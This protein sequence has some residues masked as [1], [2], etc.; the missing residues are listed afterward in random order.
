MQLQAFFPDAMFLAPDVADTG[1]VVFVRGQQAGAQQMLLPAIACVSAMRL[2][3]ALRSAIVHSRT[4]L[5]VRRTAPSEGRGPAAASVL[6]GGGRHDGQQRHPPRPALLVPR[7]QGASSSPAYPA[8]NIAPSTP[9][10]PHLA[11]MHGAATAVR[12]VPCHARSG[13]RAQHPSF[14]ELQRSSSAKQTSGG[15][16]ESCLRVRRR[17]GW[18]P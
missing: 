12:S 1:T 10:I 6:P 5:W 18:W 9:E 13:M 7:P 8:P 15:S 3:A 14:R 2:C 4:C 16:G 17:W 11:L